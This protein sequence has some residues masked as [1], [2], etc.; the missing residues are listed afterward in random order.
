MTET[1]ESKKINTLKIPQFLGISGL[2][3]L[4]AIVAVTM[5]FPF[6]WVVSTSLKPDTEIFSW[7]PVWIPSSLTLEQY[8]ACLQTANFSLYLLNSTFVTIMRT[9]FTV[10]VASL[11]GYAFARLHFRGRDLLFLAVLAT[12]MIPFQAVLIPLFLLVKWIPLAGGN[13][14]FGKGGIGW[15]DSY[16]GLIVPGVANAFDIFLFRQFFVTVPQELEDAARIDGASD[17]G[18]FWRIMLPLSAAPTV[19]V[20]IFTFQSCWNEFLWPL[21]VIQS[22]KMRTVQLGLAQFSQQHIVDWGPLM[23]GAVVASLPVIL[24]FLLMQRHFIQAVTTTGIKA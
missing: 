23:A 12:L 2:Y 11:A 18:I 16:W 15:I 9:V 21:V 13:D 8:V 4:L 20:I 3:L 10:V 14:L 24:I 1:H 5:L 7:P 6:F 19:V 17:F 22:S